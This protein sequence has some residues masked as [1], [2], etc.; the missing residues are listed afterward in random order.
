MNRDWTDILSGAALALLGLGIALHA[1]MRLD[2]GTPRNMGPGFFPVVLGGVLALL[3]MVIAVPAWL[4]GADPV[5]IRW[6]DAGAVIVSILL[7]GL[8]IPYLGLMVACVGAVLVAS[9]PSPHAGWQ[10]RLVLAVVVTV[11][12]YIVFIEG[13]RM[14]LP[15]WPRLT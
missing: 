1:G 9:L 3:G 13:L 8:G 5:Q 7:F 4:R 2:I 11:L 6:P 12:V 15:V 10:W 14:S